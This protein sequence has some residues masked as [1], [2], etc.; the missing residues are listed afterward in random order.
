[1]RMTPIVICSKSGSSP[2]RMAGCPELLYTC[3]SSYL[4]SWAVQARF[5]V[6]GGTYAVSI[7]IRDAFRRLSSPGSFTVTLQKQKGARG[8]SDS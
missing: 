2:S 4:I 7:R 6:G 3:V 8:P 5:V 1:M